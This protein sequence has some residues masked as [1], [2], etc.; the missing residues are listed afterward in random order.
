MDSN[1][2]EY[3]IKQRQVEN[4]YQTFGFWGIQALAR[5]YCDE[6]NEQQTLEWPEQIYRGCPI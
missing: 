4:K 5:I 3:Q 1:I 2:K 6:L